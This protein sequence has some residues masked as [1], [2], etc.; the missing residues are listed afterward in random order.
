[1]FLLL[2]A[3]GAGG[4]WL[5]LDSEVPAA[6]STQK[7]AKP[8]SPTSGEEPPTKT[9]ATT[10]TAEPE[11][12]PAGEPQRPPTTPGGGMSIG[13][14]ATVSQFGQLDF[15]NFR[16][17][18]LDGGRVRY[19]ETYVLHAA[20]SQ[21]IEA[22]RQMLKGVEVTL[23]D[24]GKPA[25]MLSA[26]QA[27]VELSR[28]ANGRPSLREDKA[29]DLR[30]AKFWT[31]PGTKA[32]GLEL[33]VDQALVQV[34]AETIEMRTPDERT[35]VVVTMAGERRGTLHGQGLQVRMPRDSSSKLQ[36]LDIDV[37][38]EPVLETDG[39]TVRAR[40]RLHYTE[41]LA[42]GTG[43]LQLDDDVQLDLARGDL[44]GG[45][46]R[47]ADGR[48][49]TVHADQFLGWLLRDPTAKSGGVTWRLLRLTGSP[50]AVEIPGG[51]LLA[52]QLSAVIGP[53][54][55]PLVISA[56]GGEARVEQ[57]ERR[58]D[59]PLAGLAKGS[60]PR[61]VH[62]AQ[63]AESVGAAHRAF[64]F[65]EWTL[66]PLQEM[67][68]VTF[69]GAGKLADERRTIEA[70]RGLRVF[71]PSSA[72]EA[73]IVTGAGDVR[74]V[75]H[76]SMPGEPDLTATGN[77]GLRL[78]A[79]ADGEHLQLGPSETDAAA[80]D[81]WAAHRYV[82]QRGEARVDGSGS[83]ELVHAGERTTLHLRA[84]VGG[85]RARLGTGG[86]E[87]AA[88][89]YLDAE[90]T[91]DDLRALRIAG[92]PA[93][94]TIAR[95]G[96]ILR[97]EAPRLEQLGPGALVLLPPNGET[98]AIWNGLAETA[99]LPR[100]TGTLAAGPKT[101]AQRIDTT[102]PRIEIHYLGGR[103][104]V[105]TAFADA[106]HP[107]H[108]SA[109]VA[110]LDG[111]APTAIA[112]DAGRL[113]L[114]PF[115]VPRE[116]QRALFGGVS[117]VLADLGAEVLGGAWLIVDDVREFVARDPQHGVMTGRGHRLVLSQSAEAALFVGDAD[118]LAP[119]Y[120]TRE[121]D[122]RSI[123]ATGAQ[124]RAFQDQDLRLQALPTFRDRSTVLLPTVTL[125][126]AGSENP[127]SHV[128]AICRGAIDVTTAAVQFGGPVVAQALRADGTDDLDGIHI[129][130]QQLAMQRDPKT[131]EPLRMNG[132]TV[133]LDWNRLVATSAQ[134]ELDLPWHRLTVR[135]PAGARVVLQN[136]LEYVSPWIEV[137]YETLAIHCFDGRLQQND[138]PVAND[139]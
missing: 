14:G 109:D 30:K 32:A 29:I 79:N 10:P 123:A 82:V 75:Q 65:P 3:L 69:E 111:R 81:R 71:R 114:L 27:F 44:F 8:T 16:E 101:A 93:V 37:L 17:V 104:A 46:K 129:D 22:G 36:R 64:G 9:P 91:G 7:S 42:A 40:G 118:T 45:A 112:L 26:D 102:A 62:L 87:L 33:T 86:A 96:Q 12:P 70:S 1:M 11:Q 35:P 52:P 19:D 38:H 108:A 34:G 131:G 6:A 73:A 21:P 68:I 89:H 80:R 132:R 15:S 18:Q 139:R 115:A 117:P 134:V 98:P 5:A 49:G 47:S 51:R 90:V 103:D 41:Q 99:T 106:E 126:Q 85:I 2:V 130:A 57:T 116:A 124:V 127:L 122:G 105:V 76:G 78:V 113:Q 25:A 61:R 50:A 56:H 133:R 72:H 100:L 24:K 121:R 60:S 54:G 74:I 13:N 84:P 48:T 53:F 97:A 120:V 66:R 28:D 94:A 77:D 95:G 110:Y 128:R 59:S 23:F 20:D 31:L 58:E 135:D 67:Q 55:T 43:L 107:A 83:C 4:L 136:G 92:L 119:A 63:P 39:M 137:N 125:H 88:V 138:A